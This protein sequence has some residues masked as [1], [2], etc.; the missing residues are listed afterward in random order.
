MED[1]LD[2]G[3]A[4]VLADEHRGVVGVERERLLVLHLLHGAVEAVDR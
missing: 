4:V 2:R 3:R 1:E